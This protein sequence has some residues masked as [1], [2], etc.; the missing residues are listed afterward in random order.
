[1]CQGDLNRP[2]WESA[3]AV[4]CAGAAIGGPSVGL[5]MVRGRRVGCATGGPAYVLGCTAATLRSVE[6]AVKRGAQS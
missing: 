6:S 1:M 4:I 2:A 5:V 3:I